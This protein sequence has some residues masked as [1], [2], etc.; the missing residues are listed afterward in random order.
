[1]HGWTTSSEMGTEVWRYANNRTYIATYRNGCD[2][3]EIC[4]LV[5]FQTTDVHLYISRIFH[6]ECTQFDMRKFVTF[7][8]NLFLLSQQRNLDF[9]VPFCLQ[10]NIHVADFFCS[11]VEAYHSFLVVPIAYCRLVLVN[12]SGVSGGDI[13][14]TRQGDNAFALSHC[15]QN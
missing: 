5:N 3:A 14:I 15:R 11:E 1:M 7:K 2:R 4:T 13:R 8:C 12:K 9:G 6:F 10:G